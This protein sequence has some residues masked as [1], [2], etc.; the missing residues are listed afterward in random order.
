MA[1]MPAKTRP[2]RTDIIRQERQGEA[3]SRNGGVE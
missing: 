3:H 2:S 1:F